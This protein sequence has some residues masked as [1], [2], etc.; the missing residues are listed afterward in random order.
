VKADSYRC[1]IAMVYLRLTRFGMAT[2]PHP[3]PI[4]L[5][6]L[7]DERWELLQRVASS[8][9][10]QKSNRAREFL[11]FVGKRSLRDPESPIREQ[12]IGSEVFGRPTT[13]DTS[14]DTLVRVQASQLRKKLQQYF[15]EEGRDEPLI[16]EMPKGSYSLI[17]HPRLSAEA[18]LPDSP[19]VPVWRRRG[20]A[21]AWCAASLLAVLCAVLIYLNL[22]LQRRAEFGLGRQPMVDAFWRQ[23]FSNPHRTYLVVADGTLLVL[24]DQIKRHVT[25]TEYE[26]KSFDRLATER[27]A[28]TELRNITINVVNRQYTGIGDASLAHRLGLVSA[29]NEVPMDVILARNIALSQLA[30]SNVILLGSR[31]ANPWVNLFEDKLNFQ[32]VFEETPRSARF[33]NRNPKAGEKPVYEGRWSS[34][35]YCRVAYLPNAK[36][37]GSVLLISG[38]DVQSTDAGGD[39]VSS[40]AWIGRLRTALGLRGGE[41]VP[42]FEV[43]L[44]GQVVNAIVPRFELVALRRH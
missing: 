25:L 43:L 18:A 39:F 3:P 15:T 16:I 22:G 14:Q 5:V 31:R 41:P 21:L 40:E 23:M 17:F 1:V 27:I 35:G 11:L 4:T 24:E 37:V 44:Q 29:A 19:Q 33:I 42:H 12:E 2:D 34:I 38:T 32:T 7:Q 28:D 36:G 10:F 26:R 9:S 20:L 30:S 8:I 13:Y 6:P